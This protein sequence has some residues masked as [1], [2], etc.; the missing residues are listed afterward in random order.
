M[1]IRRAVAKDLPGLA[2]LLDQVLMV[3]HEGRPDLFVAGT[4]KYSDDELLDMIPDD[5]RPIFV[6]VEED[7]PD[8][9]LLGYAFCKYED[10]TGSNFL[11]SHRTLYVDDICVDEKARGSH[12]GTALYQHLLAFAREQGFYNVTLNVWS[13]NP[14]AQAFY[15]AM[16]MKPYKVGMEAIL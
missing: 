8:G 7:A 1:L 14:G 6:A 9:E 16:G 11:V 10:T 2:N 12:V 15:E 4:R 3:H 13:C 5:E